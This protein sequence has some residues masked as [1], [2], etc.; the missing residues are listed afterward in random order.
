VV[1]GISADAGPAP[2]TVPA[3]SAA[4]L[5]RAF[6]T[7]RDDAASCRYVLLSMLQVTP[8][9][10]RLRQTAP[11]GTTTSVAVVPDAAHCDPEPGGVCLDAALPSQLLS[12]AASCALLRVA[13]ELELLTECSEPQGPAGP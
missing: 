5:A 6:A 3:Q 13:L 12:C 9:T 2:R 10:S 11:D 7:V 4:D 8:R 1:S